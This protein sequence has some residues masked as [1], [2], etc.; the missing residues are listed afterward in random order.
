MDD[1]VFFFKQKK[2]Y[3]VEKGLVGSGMYIRDRVKR[4][5]KKQY[6]QNGRYPGILRTFKKL[7]RNDSFL[8]GLLSNSGIC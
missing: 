6:A 4:V 2:A 1:D 5:S 7:M 8:T 3:D